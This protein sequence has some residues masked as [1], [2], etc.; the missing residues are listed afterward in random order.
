MVAK[1]DPHKFI[2]P[3][4]RFSALAPYS[5]AQFPPQITSLQAVGDDP[6]YEHLRQL[7]VDFNDI[8]TFVELEG[9]KFI[10]NFMLFSISHNKLK[11]VS[12]DL[13]LQC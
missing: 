7:I 4:S 3:A 1:P 8:G 6:T 12:V 10:D 9:T 13:F 2:V 5:K 11:T